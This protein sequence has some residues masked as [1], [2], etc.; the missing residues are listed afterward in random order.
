MEVYF[1]CTQ[2]KTLVEQGHLFV[3]R[4]WDKNLPILCKLVWREAFHSSGVGLVRMRAR[5]EASLIEKV[6][7]IQ[8]TLGGKNWLTV[9]QPIR[10]GRVQNDP[11]FSCCC[12]WDWQRLEDIDGFWALRKAECSAAGGSVPM[13]AVGPWYLWGLIPG[14]PRPNSRNQNPWMLKAL[15]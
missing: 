3:P 13:R 12:H 4:I 10:Q 6:Q 1:L 15:I 5:V 14:R 8:D 7:W 9:A 2:W 11:M